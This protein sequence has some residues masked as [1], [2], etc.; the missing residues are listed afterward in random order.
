MVLEP[1]GIGRQGHSPFGSLNILDIDVAF[2]GA[3]ASEGIVVV[4]DK[5]VDIVN[6]AFGI[7]YPFDI[8]LIPFAQVSCPVV[9]H[10]Q[11]ESLLL[12]FAFSH[13]SCGLEM[14]YDMGYG[15][16]IDASK[17]P[18]QFNHLAFGIL[19]HLGVESVGYRMRVSL[20]FDGLVIVF[21]LGTGNSLVIIYGRESHDILVRCGRAPLLPLG[22]IINIV[23]NILRCPQRT[24]VFP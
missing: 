20:D 5:A 4:L 22:G 10:K 1:L 9:L 6:G 23:Q 11:A 2:P 12:A 18:W 17:F 14:L 16:I 7:L 15:C 3:L 19:H 13:L 8:V 24:E 21:H